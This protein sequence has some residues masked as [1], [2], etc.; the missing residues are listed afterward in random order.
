MYY[1]VDAGETEFGRAITTWSC[2]FEL[3]TSR[4]F[5]GREQEEP[6]RSRGQVLTRYRID[7]RR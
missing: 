3:H 2:N 7:H 5:T 6:I 1:V 4:W